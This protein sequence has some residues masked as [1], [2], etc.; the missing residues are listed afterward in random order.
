MLPFG[1]LDL[2]RRS[3][4]FTPDEQ[5]TVMTLWAIARSPLMHGGDMT[6][7]DE[8]TLGLLTQPEVIA[9]NQDSRDN[10]PLFD[11]DGLIAWTA[12]GATGDSYLA[13]FNARDRSPLS[14]ER[15][16]FDG[17]LE[18]G[19]RAF[20]TALLEV[21]VVPGTI[22]QL[23]AD[24]G[25]GGN[26]DHHAVVW[27]DPVLEGP[28]GVV[29]LLDLPWEH[30][31]SRWGSVTS[32]RAPGEREL[33]LG[34]R[35]LDRGLLV[36]TKSVIA[37]RVPEGYERLVAECGFEGSALPRGEGVIARCAVYR[38]REGNTNFGETL[39][40]PLEGET[41]SVRLDALGFEPVDGGSSVSASAARASSVGVSTVR[42]SIVDVWTGTD[43]GM[44]ETVFSRTIPWHGAGLFRVRLLP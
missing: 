37:L 24:D 43:L 26:G 23:V 19:A 39:E 2:G 42:A 35:P 5:R 10:R 20:Q 7:M 38:E 17:A 44:F 9:L 32:Y 8:L 27:G 18:G 31:T 14:D 4:R 13:L 21:P 22:I 33:L 15:R 30:A 16:I 1:A 11:E 12:T 6:K 29:S 34:G 40:P 36:H 25:R 3:S 28:A 41:I